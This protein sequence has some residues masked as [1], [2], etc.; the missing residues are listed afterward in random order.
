MLKEEFNAMDILADEELATIFGGTS[1]NTGSSF[2][3]AEY[4]AIKQELD[5]AVNSNNFDSFSSIVCK[6]TAIY[7]QGFFTRVVKDYTKSRYLTTSN[8]AKLVADVVAAT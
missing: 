5:V 3:E 6:Y 4:A 1:A 2:T 7:G 8:Y